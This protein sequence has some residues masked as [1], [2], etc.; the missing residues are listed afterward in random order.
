MLVIELP[1][2]LLCPKPGMAERLLVSRPCCGRGCFA[3]IRNGLFS[4]SRS[5]ICLARNRRMESAK[6]PVPLK[7]ILTIFP[8]RAA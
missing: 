6:V 7:M 5:P 8:F 4:A 1:A 2:V 3:D